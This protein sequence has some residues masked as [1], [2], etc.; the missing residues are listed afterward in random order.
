VSAF[1]AVAGNRIH[2]RATAASACGREVPDADA[3]DWLNH[4]DRAAIVYL[5]MGTVWNRNLDVFRVVIE[6]VREDDIALIVTIGRDNDPATL[7]PQP[8]NMFVHR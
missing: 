6:A 2:C 1:L 3:P 4:L 7:G 8:D 5:T